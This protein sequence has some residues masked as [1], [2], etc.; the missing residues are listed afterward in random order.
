MCGRQQTLQ[1]KSTS[2]IIVFVPNFLAPAQDLKSGGTEL[3][4]PAWFRLRSKKRRTRVTCRGICWLIDT[5]LG[6]TYI[7][8][9]EDSNIN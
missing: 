8:V 5:S 4:M 2:D 3:E 7:K 1:R 6:H 9:Y